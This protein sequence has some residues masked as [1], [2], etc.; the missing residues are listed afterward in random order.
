MEH[1]DCGCY[2]YRP[3]RITEGDSG[4]VFDDIP[5]VDYELEV[6]AE[7]GAWKNIWDLEESLS[8][9]ELMDLYEATMERQHRMM[10]AVAAAM[11]ADVGGDEEEHYLNTTSGQVSSEH[12]E[13]TSVKEAAVLGIG[14]SRIEGE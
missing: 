1:N 10:K 13:I 12:R 4:V 5:L 14:Y 2:G 3:K 7:C 11:G 6:F 9:E 8:L